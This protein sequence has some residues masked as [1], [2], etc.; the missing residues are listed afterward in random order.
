MLVG[1]S[2]VFH[3]LQLTVT[4]DY[5][6]VENMHC[7]HHN[8]GLVCC[9]PTSPGL[10]CSLLLA[11]LLYGERQVPVTT[12]RTPLNDTATVVQDGSFGEEVFLV[13]EL[14]ACSECNDDR[15]HLSGCHSGST[16]TF[17][18]GCHGC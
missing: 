4:C 13:P 15:Q 1:L 10:V 3:L 5:P 18:S 11:G 7:G 17:V 14:T 2:D 12:K 6:E 16:C 8:S 9:F